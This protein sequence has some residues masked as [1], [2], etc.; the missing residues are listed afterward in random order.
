[1]P[2]AASLPSATPNILFWLAALAGVALLPFVLAM[3]T[4]FAK[5]VIVGGII[6]YALG[7][8]QIPPNT[9]ITGIALIL[10]V[11]I[12]WP[13]GLATR[14]G[15]LT[16]MNEAEARV[17]ASGPPQG[18]R[19]QGERDGRTDPPA[20]EWSA[21]DWASL[22]DSMLRT[23]PGPLLRFL[24]ANSRP[25]NIELFQ[26]LQARVFERSGAGAS[27]PPAPGRGFE[28]IEDPVARL[29]YGVTVIAPAFVL[30][31][32]TEALQVAFLIFVPF[33]IVDLVVSNVL[34]A[35][36]MQMMSPVT[37]S[38]PLKLLLFVLTDGWRFVLQGVVLG[39]NY[40]PIGGSP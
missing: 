1:M 12:M 17:Q 11:H 31:E 9:V 2:D 7:T 26:R 28:A 18:A 3:V 10:T 37:I 16:A 5:L 29:T 8:Q 21:A 4:P 20:K 6:R 27:R 14:D 35:L 19:K 38:L 36:G 33:V 30:T 34:L 24:E 22:G 23:A 32:L 25:G 39:Y 15:V 40:A 13:V